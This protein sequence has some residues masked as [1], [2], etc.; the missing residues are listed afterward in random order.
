MEYGIK[1]LGYK[2]SRARDFELSSLLALL[3]YSANK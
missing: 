1:E 3:F 2:K